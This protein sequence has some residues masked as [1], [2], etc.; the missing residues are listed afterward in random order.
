[1]QLG[2]PSPSV[3]IGTL[4]ISIGS[5]SQSISMVSNQPSLSSSLSV[6]LPIP[7]LSVSS[8]SELSKGKA[9]SVS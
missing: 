9:S 6:L 3:S 4:N 5:V 8:H 7:S 2:S 1:M